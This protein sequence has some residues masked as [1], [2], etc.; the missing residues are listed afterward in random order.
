MLLSRSWVSEKYRE[1]VEILGQGYMNP[2]I[3][4]TYILL[5]SRIGLEDGV[6]T[7]MIQM[8][9]C[10]TAILLRPRTGPKNIVVAA[11]INVDRKACVCI[12]VKT[13][14]RYPTPI[15]IAR[16]DNHGS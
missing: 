1:A 9:I 13:R 16:P 10:T 14:Y 3:L 2:C 15:A 6:V 8:S 12:L 4:T 5:L 11:E 7:A